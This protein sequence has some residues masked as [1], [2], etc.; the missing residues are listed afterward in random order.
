MNSD[1]G[2]LGQAPEGPEQLAIWQVQV[3]PTPLTV[4]VVRY[5]DGRAACRLNTG[6][7]VSAILTREQAASLR[8]ALADCLGTLW[9]L[10]RQERRRVA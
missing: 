7:D 10:E 2:P 4:A 8:L 6:S 3:D 1:P 5:R 9:Q